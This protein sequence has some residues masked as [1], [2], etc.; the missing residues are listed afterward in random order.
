MADVEDYFDRQGM[1]KKADERKRIQSDANINAKLDGIKN[2]AASLRLHALERSGQRRPN[3]KSTSAIRNAERDISR[4]ESA[5]S[6]VEGGVVPSDNLSE[7]FSAGTYPEAD[8][9]P[10]GTDYLRMPD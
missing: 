4:L 3:I 7:P 1:R 9:G 10:D 2:Q 8:T 5:T 6:V